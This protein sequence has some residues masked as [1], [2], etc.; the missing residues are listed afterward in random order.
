MILAR[1]ETSFFKHLPKK[2]QALIRKDPAALPLSRFAEAI[3]EFQQPGRQVAAFGTG[4]I[5]LRSEDFQAEQ[6]S[7][8][9]VE[10]EIDRGD[11]DELQLAIHL[12]RGGRPLALPFLPTVNCIMEYEAGIWRLGEIAVNLRIPLADPT[13]LAS[14]T[15]QI[16]VTRNEGDELTPLHQLRVLATAEVTYA[17]TFPDFGYACSLSDLGGS[18]ESESSL[19]AATL[20]D[21]QLAGGNVGGYV[22]SINDCLGNPVNHF[23]ATAA[24]EKPDS[25]LRAFC[26]DESMVIRYSDDGQASTCLRQGD[27]LP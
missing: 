1:D 3:S 24:P 22:Y 25:R 8:I 5:L 21:D 10:N 4:P 6:A 2:A 13:F 15:D 23:W 26:F 17:A 7:E 19:H 12:Y 18:G 14:I 27:P 11:E 16:R 9:T 20:I